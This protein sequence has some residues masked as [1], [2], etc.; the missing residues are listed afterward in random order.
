[1]SRMAFTFVTSAHCPECD[2]R[3]SEDDVAGFLRMSESDTG[4]SELVVWPH[5]ERAIGAITT[6]MYDNPLY[7]VLF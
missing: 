6:A 3:I 4:S 5:C 7:D 1:M 2:S